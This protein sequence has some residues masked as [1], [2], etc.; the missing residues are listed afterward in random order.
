MAAPPDSYRVGFDFGAAGN[1]WPIAVATADKEGR[2]T[3][4][5][6]NFS[7]A[8]SAGLD[9]VIASYLWNFGDGSTSPVANPSHTYAVPGKYVATLTVTDKSGCSYREHR[10][11]GSNHTV[12]P[13]PTNLT[14]VVQSK[15]IGWKLKTRVKLD[16]M[17]NAAS[18]S[19]YLVERCI[20]VGCTNFRSDRH[21]ACEQC[22]ILRQSRDWGHDLPLPGRCNQLRR[23]IPVFEHRR[24]YDTVTSAAADQWFIRARLSRG[25]R[26]HALK[27][28][29]RATAGASMGC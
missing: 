25:V 10:G 8:G 3:P 4:L 16:W 6:V 7:S 2:D 9:G 29:N 14:A 12:P 21:A 19:G 5:A 27:N 17:N 24:S 11:V 1:Q 22:E 23:T 15:T 20:N 26:K 18:E 13:A 28:G